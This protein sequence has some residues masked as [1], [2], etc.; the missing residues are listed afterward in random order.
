MHDIPKARVNDRTKHSKELWFTLL[1][2]YFWWIVFFYSWFVKLIAQKTFF[3]R[4]DPQQGL[5]CSDFVHMY[6]MAKTASVSFFGAHNL[7]DSNLQLYYFNQAISPLTAV[8][9]MVGQYEPLVYAA[10]SPLSCFSI[11][12]AWFI[13][14]TLSAL[15]LIWIC[16][17][18][19]LH[20]GFGKFTTVFFIVASFASYP[21]W[22]VFRSGQ[23]SLFL[24]LSTTCFFYLL[25]QRKYFKAGLFGVLA[26]IKIQYLPFLCA[27]GFVLGRS[28]FATGLAA[29]FLGIAVASSIVFSP[30]NA[31]SFPQALLFSQTNLMTSAGAM[32]NVRG[33]LTTFSN[34]P[35]SFIF[36]VA[37]AISV[38]AVVS[39]FVGWILLFQAGQR[40]YGAAN[41]SQLTEDVKRVYSKLMVAASVFFMLLTSPHTHLQDYCLAVIPCGLLYSICSQPIIFNLARSRVL[42]I[43]TLILSYPLLGW[44]FHGFTLP[45]VLKY[46]PEHFTFAWALLLL[47][48]TFS[49]L[50]SINEI[51]HQTTCEI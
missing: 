15:A 49:I 47:L 50:L 1:T 46:L 26:I 8:G 25:E 14:I 7:Y 35:E 11:L 13:Q 23:V 32:E 16:Y 39:M 37:L 33:L 44:L 5:T 45:G 3:A 48:L 38:S 29:G 12:V 31:L 6:S 17:K 20:E 21:V 9:Q 19:S 28:K 40:K 41:S 2:V 36:K 27:I 18:I 22:L 24:L 4:I 42:L 34:L 51:E 30:L 43:R 10:L